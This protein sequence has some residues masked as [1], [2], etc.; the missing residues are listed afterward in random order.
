MDTGLEAIA[1]SDR[2]VVLTSGKIGEE[3]YSKDLVEKI[4]DFK[5]VHFICVYCGK[6]SV[7]L[8]EEA[9]SNFNKVTCITHKI[10]TITS[11]AVSAVNLTNKGLY[12]QKKE[13]ESLE[14][15]IDSNVDKQPEEP[16]SLSLIHI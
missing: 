12:G 9:L 15:Q 13:E 1:N 2:C 4:H 11:E 16:N 3:I 8:N 14:E 10:S 6:N 7:H 5:N